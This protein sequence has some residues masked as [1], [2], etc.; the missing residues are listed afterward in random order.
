MI[1]YAEVG[2]HKTYLNSLDVRTVGIGGGSMV[3]LRDGKAVGTGRSVHIADLEYE[4]HSK[5]EDIVERASQACAP[6]PQTRNTHVSNAQM[7]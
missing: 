6:L 3:Q 7:A 1:Q 5:P 4:V 2:G